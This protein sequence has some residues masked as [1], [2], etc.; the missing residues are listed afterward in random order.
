MNSMHE[1]NAINRFLGKLDLGLQIRTL[2]P[3]TRIEPKTELDG[4]F[5]VFELEVLTTCKVYV[6][7]IHGDVPKKK[8][9]LI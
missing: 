9:S 6:R 8:Y 5:Q 2:V 4:T 3:T 1:F 7:Y